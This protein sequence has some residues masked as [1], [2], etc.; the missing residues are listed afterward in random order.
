MCKQKFVRRLH[1]SGQFAASLGDNVRVLAEQVP[2]HCVGDMLLALNSF[3]QLIDSERPPFH[4]SLYVWSMVFT[5]CSSDFIAQFLH[6]SM[7]IGEGVSFTPG[8]F[9]RH[10]PLDTNSGDLPANIA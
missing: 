2:F 7:I 1:H 5:H 6:A 4:V 10:L 8:V 3:E 9:T